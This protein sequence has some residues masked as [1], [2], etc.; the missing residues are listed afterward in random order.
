MS[1]A[2]LPDLEPL[3]RKDRV[4]AA[5]NLPGVPA[6]TPGKV[7]MVSGFTWV[8][9]WVRFE[10]GV[11][12]GSIDRKQLVR[13]GEPYGEELAELRANAAAPEAAADGPTLDGADGAGAGGVEVGGVMIPGH[14]LE[15]SKK[16]RELLGA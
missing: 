12:R 1:T 14:L 5:A 8:R 2:V 15:R 6:G 16:R 4:V 11:A 13:P 3:K 10:N 7:I 9:Y